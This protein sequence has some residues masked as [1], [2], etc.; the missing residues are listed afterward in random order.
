[1]MVLGGH[2]KNNYD[3]SLILRFN[4]TQY[5]NGAGGTKQGSTGISLKR[6]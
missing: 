4:K 2:F 1:M 5:K 3:E 6:I